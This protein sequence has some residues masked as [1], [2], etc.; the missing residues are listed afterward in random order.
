MPPVLE[1][2]PGFLR[3]LHSRRDHAIAKPPKP[4]QLDKL[5]KRIGARWKKR[6]A[7]FEVGLSAK[8]GLHARVE[9]A[10]KL[11]DGPP[12]AEL[13]HDA[14]VAAERMIGFD[15]DEDVSLVWL[16]H[17]LGGPVAAVE[18]ELGALG[19]E[20]ANE[21]TGTAW[22]N[23]LHR[24][25][26]QFIRS[27]SFD[28]TRDI[29]CSMNE[30]D[31][32]AARTAGASARE[33]AEG[34]ARHAIDFMFPSEP[35]AKEDLAAILAD[36]QVA[37]RAWDASQLLAACDDRALAEGFFA[38]VAWQAYAYLPDL[39]LG[40]PLEDVPEFLVGIVSA[41]EKVKTVG[42]AEWLAIAETLASV[43]DER[44][45]GLL[46]R[47]LLHKFAGPTAV[48]FFRAHPELAKTALAPVAA[49]KTKAGEAARAI[50]E[51]GARSAAPVELAPPE[52]VPLLLREPPWR[53]KKKAR[54]LTVLD[55]ATPPFAERIHWDA[56]ER[57][58]ASTYAWGWGQPL[59]MTDEEREAWRALPGRRHVDVWPRNVGGAYRITLIADELG[60]PWWN[61][62]ADALS[63]RGALH[64]IAR[65]GEPALAG[66]FLR[67]PFGYDERIFDAMM[68]VESPRV[69]PIVAHGLQRKPYRKRSQAWLQRHPEA[70]ALGLLPLAF[71]AA[72][73]VRSEAEEALRTMAG[74]GLEG[75][76]R[77]VADRYGAP[78]RAGL[79]AFLA[80]DPLSLL[81]VG[82]KVPDWLRLDELPRPRTKKGQ[83]LDDEA[84]A[85]LV[86]VLRGSELVPPYPGVELLREALDAD[87]LADLV[88]AVF[89]AWHL[90]GAKGTWPWA[91]HGLAHF[92]D[93]RVVRRFAP[94]AAE[95]GR[96]DAKKALLAI[97][98]LAELGTDGALLHLGNLEAK[99]R[100]QPVR[101]AARAALAGIAQARGLSPDELADRAVPTLDLDPDGSA[102]LDYGARTFRV[103]FDETLA[104][105]VLS[106]DG[107]RATSA[108][109]PSGADDRAK[110]KLAVDRFKALKTDAQ[111]VA[112]SQIRRL[113][114]AMTGGRRFRPG[115]FDA[116][117]A[118]HPLVVHLARRLVWGAFD[119]S[120]ALGTTFRVAED[121]TLADHEDRT[122]ALPAAPIGIVHP[123]V[124]ADELRATWT[125]VFADYEILQPFEQLGRA[126][127]VPTAELGEKRSMQVAGHEAKPGA[128]LGVLDSRGWDRIA[129]SWVT[130]YSRSARRRD[131]APARFK[132]GFQPGFDL[133]DVANAPMQT[134]KG[135]ELEG[136]ERLGDVEPI[137]L[138][139][140]LRDVEAVR[141]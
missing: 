13:D 99:A 83:A 114:R 118:R 87:A 64:V 69:A 14:F 100:S 4:P 138:S 132:I 93:E 22:G 109:R 29:L 84:T 16:A 60:L 33:R 104:P 73:K 32:A 137:D 37:Q 45:T 102:T 52:D 43:V 115:D 97:E 38:A 130:E 57:E 9:A 124:L 134:L 66:L 49:A 116:L 44:C 23:V 119:G 72:G 27:C 77:G 108:P 54:E 7:S 82:G 34:R 36:P 129:D 71:G 30:T 128:I 11:L 53:A 141:R 76:L 90:A 85:A 121:G 68:H 41:A 105:V 94:Y 86:E 6:R 133:A 2:T 55:L 20:V 122:L 5:W 75:V 42:N 67:D 112:A 58:A 25:P 91:V 26:S 15:A 48:A 62:H 19:L 117:V 107:T 59:P 78:A 110:A 103:V 74:L 1:P 51:S 31:Y 123:L 40:L 92:G 111:S 24:K 21:R 18:V 70:A 127:F 79:D 131:G 88:W 89:S 101:E 113:E 95:W 139:E 65:W 10:M 120:G 81:D 35:W 106:Q 125:R 47:L 28:A 126:L 80:V 135:L 17:A 98:T 63:N 140:A 56:A 61:E 46:A 50:L 96:T 12:P 3:R 39:A 8:G 136:A